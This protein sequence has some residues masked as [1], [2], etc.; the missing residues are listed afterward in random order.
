LKSLKLNIFPSAHLKEP[1]K[2]YIDKLE[3]V[4]LLRSSKREGLIRARL[5]GAALAQA[6]VIV[7]L[8]SH[9]E[10]MEGK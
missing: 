5:N 8:D 10:C 3:K 1:L 6:E 9:C 4:K 7:F 2:E